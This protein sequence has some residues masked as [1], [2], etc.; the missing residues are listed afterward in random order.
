MRIRGKTTKMAMN[1]IYGHAQLLRLSMENPDRIFFIIFSIWCFIQMVGRCVTY[2]AA[3]PALG[4]YS[5]L[6]SVR[7]VAGDV[8]T[9]R[10]PII[11]VMFIVIHGIV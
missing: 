8:Y 2:C 5:Q 11:P 9:A 7:E 6:P 1:M 4:D 3:Y 10:R